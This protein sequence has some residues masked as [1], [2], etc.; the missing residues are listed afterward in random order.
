MSANETTGE[1]VTTESSTST[2]NVKAV[3]VNGLALFDRKGE[4]NSLSVR[5]KRWERGFERSNQQRSES[6][7]V[8]ALGRH[9]STRNLLH[10]GTCWSRCIT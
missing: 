6:N 7:V 9:R 8:V 2:T 1:S 10:Y 3:E 5:W 4:P